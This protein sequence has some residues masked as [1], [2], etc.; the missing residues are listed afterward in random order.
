VLGTPFVGEIDA[1]LAAVDYLLG[2]W[3]PEQALEF[4]PAENASMS[5]DSW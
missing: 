3:T 4:V 1:V 2:Q 5:A